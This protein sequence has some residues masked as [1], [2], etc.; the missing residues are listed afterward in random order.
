MSLILDE[1]MRLIR[2][3][4]LDT[5]PTSLQRRELQIPSKLS[6]YGIYTQKKNVRNAYIHQSLLTIQDNV[7]AG[8]WHCNRRPPKAQ[9]EKKKM[10][11]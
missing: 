1:C 2:M 8:G 5:K 11:E 3:Y 4:G 9:N 10:D 6:V 7:A